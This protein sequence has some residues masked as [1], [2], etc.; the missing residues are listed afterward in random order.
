MTFRIYA[1]IFCL[2]ITQLQAQQNSNL[3]QTNENESS[4]WLTFQPDEQKS[5]IELKEDTI[6]KRSKD[7]DF[8]IL[9]TE[10][11]LRGY[12]HHR[13]RQ[14]YKGVPIEG[15]TLIMHEKNNLVTHANGKLAY[16][17]SINTNPSITKKE[18]L[19]IVQNDINA[20]VYAW[21]NPLYED[22]LKQVNNDTTATHLPSGELI[23]TKSIAGT[24]KNGYKLAYKFTIYTIEPLAIKTAYVNAHNG[25]IIGYVE[26]MNCCTNHVTAQGA[27]HYSDE[28]EFT[29]CFDDNVYSLQSEINGGKFKSI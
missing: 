16:N 5:L 19:E 29:T 10:N 11:D 21:E 4:L 20:N 9:T 22:M 12:Q 2:G 17:F 24:S 8:E 6:F 13:F 7:D 26:K 25:E 15:A 28:V 3:F 18:A 14:T 27:T 23:I 1:L